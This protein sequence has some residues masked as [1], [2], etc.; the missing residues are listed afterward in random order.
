MFNPSS[1]RQNLLNFLCTPNV[2]V[3]GPVSQNRSRREF[4][5]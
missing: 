3:K 5:V 4:V 2:A 1:F